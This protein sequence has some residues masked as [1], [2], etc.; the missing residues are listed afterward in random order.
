M[1]KLLI[2]LFAAT[3]L[4]TYA[5]QIGVGASARQDGG[6]VYIPFNLNEKLRIEPACS[7]YYSESDQPNGVKSELTVIEF[8]AGLFGLSTLIDDLQ[9]YYGVRAGI[10]Y[11]YNELKDPNPANWSYSNKSYQIELTPTLGVEYYFHERI[12]IGGEVGWFFRY[13]ED[14]GSSYTQRSTGTT[15]SLIARYYF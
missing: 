2:I 9:A 1:R 13:E 15:T 7:F 6:T 8:S 3:T 12:S 10:A 11:V 14:D 5:T 4:S